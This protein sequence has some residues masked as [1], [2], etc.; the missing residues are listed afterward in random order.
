MWRKILSV[1]FTLILVVAPAVQGR[2]MRA[3]PKTKGALHSTELYPVEQN[4]LWGF[5]DR[6]GRFAIAPIYR[7]AWYFSEGLAK[8][9]SGTKYGFIDR[10]GKMVIAP[11]FDLAGDFSG[12]LAVAKT[13]NKV[14]YIDKSGRWAI[15]PQY[16][17]GL[18][19]VEGLALVGVGDRVG[20]IDRKGS[21]V[22][23]PQYDDGISFS[24]KLAAVKQGGK[25]GFINQKGVMVIP[26][27]YDD[28]NAHNDGLA[29]VKAGDK[30]GYID[31][32]GKMV[33]APQ[34][35]NACTFSEGL[36]C[37]VTENK[38]GYI[39][40]SGKMVIQPLFDEVWGFSDGLAIVHVGEN[41][42]YIDKSGKFV[43]PFTKFDS[44]NSFEGGVGIAAQ[45]DNLELF[46]THGRRF[47][48][49]PRFAKWKGGDP[50][51]SGAVTVPGTT[52]RNPAGFE[53]S[54]PAGWTIS[55][56]GE[57]QLMLDAPKSEDLSDDLTISTDDAASNGNWRY[58]DNDGDLPSSVR[59]LT[60]SG[61]QQVSWGFI[62]LAKS[63]TLPGGDQFYG[64]IRLNGIS[65]GVTAVSSNDK[66]S[67]PLNQPLLEQALLDIAG[68]L[69]TSAGSDSDLA[70]LIGMS[71][72]IPPGSDPTYW[73][74][75]TTPFPYV[76]L[77]I[78][79][80]G[81]IKFYPASEKYPNLNAAASDIHTYFVR[82]GM[83][84]VKLQWVNESGGKVVWASATGSDSPHVASSNDTLY[85]GAA[86]A[87][88]KLYFAYATLFAPYTAAAAQTFK[89]TFLSTLES[90]GPS[91]TELH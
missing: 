56:E 9:E 14:G 78:P 45:R 89:E 51:E 43:V 85:I 28:M 70:S 80:G 90:L 3:V 12:G 62:H 47:A 6:S 61:G 49:I 63:T 60:L 44:V 66:I 37:V 36:A 53:I 41:Y 69:Q 15:K 29:P 65:V 88:G 18:S 13:G 91:T 48:T 26:P 74:G 22:V 87:G 23:K 82:L 25:W 24:D 81:S 7:G 30:W 58:G 40:K 19:F 86:S 77:T 1:A 35:D 72:A 20:F 39:D 21:Y 59:D 16:D 27:Q 31:I 10:A 79:K 33:I 73:S 5:V 67:K 76:E 54:I 2:Q 38:V 52:I 8:V 75:A 50:T 68:T 55:L 84:Q 32:T 83:P 34:F 4:S 11:Q 46:D 71:A 42:G 57:D 64:T 17:L